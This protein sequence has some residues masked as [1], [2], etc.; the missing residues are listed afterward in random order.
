MPVSDERDGEPMPGDTVIEFRN[1]N[2]VI[3]TEPDRS[4]RP[5]WKSAGQ[6]RLVPPVTVSGE[7]FTGELVFPPVT[8]K[9]GLYRFTIQG[10]SKDAVYIGQAKTS[11]AKRHGLYR[12]RGH[13]PILPPEDKNTSTRIAQEMIRALRAELTVH[14]DYADDDEFAN[15]ELRD[16]LERIL[17][18]ELIGTDVKIL[19]RKIP[20]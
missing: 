1:G 14:V 8:R 19:N 18:R 9:P 16:H 13:N 15:D 4:F 11:L 2:L 5:V 6:V 20:S 10:G 17:I 12:W 3:Y 7:V